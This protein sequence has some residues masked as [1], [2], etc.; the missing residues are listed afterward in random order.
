MPARTSR[1]NTS[2]VTRRVGHAGGREAFAPQPAGIAA[3]AGPALRVG[4]ITGYGQAVVH[5]EPPALANDLRLAPVDERRVNR[6]SV[7]L[8]AGLGGQ[9]RQF[10]KGGDEFR[11]A[12]RITGIIDGVDTDDQVSG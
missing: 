3:P 12:I 1:R 9:A 6:E 5:T 7:P 2:S 10:L 4:L 8:H 11:A